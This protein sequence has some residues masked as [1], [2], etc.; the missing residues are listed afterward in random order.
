MSDPSKP[1]RPLRPRWKV[2]K[3]VSVL[4]AMS[5]LAPACASRSQMH[6]DDEEMPGGG[7]IPH[8][9]SPNSDPVGEPARYGALPDFAIETAWLNG[10]QLVVHVVW[11]KLTEPNARGE[12]PLDA[13]PRA[14]PPVFTVDGVQVKPTDGAV[15]HFAPTPGPAAPPPSASSQPS[16]PAP[17]PSA[18]V[19]PPSASSTGQEGQAVAPVV[20][21]EPPGKDPGSYWFLVRGLMRSKSVQ[22]HMVFET[23]EGPFTMNATLELAG[24]GGAVKSTITTR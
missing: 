23:Q 18:P 11:Q 14:T 3:R 19:S 21:T 20:V 6:G 9:Y 4:L 8:E 15:P 1:P 12:T 5:A 22:V 17:Q 10:R 2:E 16:V 13:V 24:V 7:E